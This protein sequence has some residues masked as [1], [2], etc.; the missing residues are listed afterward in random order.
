MTIGFREYRKHCRTEA[1]AH[2]NL[3]DIKNI[4]EKGEKMLDDIKPFKDAVEYIIGESTGLNVKCG[5]SHKVNNP[6][7]LK[8]VSVMIGF[9]GDFKGQAIFTADE[10]TVYELSAAMISEPGDCDLEELAMS[11]FSE[12]AN[13]TMGRAANYFYNNGVQYDITPPTLICGRE[14]N[15]TVEKMDMV[16]IPITIGNNKTVEMGIAYL[17]T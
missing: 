3:P 2:N 15:F 4:C 14:T 9:V 16:S 13:M 10:D 5:Q 8:D 6:Y 7:I 12:L 1:D 17:R 11:A